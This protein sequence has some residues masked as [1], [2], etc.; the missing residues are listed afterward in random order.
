MLISGGLVELYLFFG[1]VTV[2]D[3]CLSKS[4]PDYQNLSCEHRGSCMRDHVLFNSL[5]ELRKRDKM[6]GLPS[7]LSLFRNKFN[8]LNNSLALK[9]DYFCY[10]TLKVL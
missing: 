8:I 6:Q 7:L 4:K 9:L 3:I 5:N 2:L 10:M 1:R